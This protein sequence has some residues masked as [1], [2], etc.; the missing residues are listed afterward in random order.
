MSG[1][2]R[3]NAKIAP[4][5]RGHISKAGASFSGARRGPCRPAWLRGSLVPAPTAGGAAA[6][7]LDGPVP[8]PTGESAEPEEPARSPIDVASLLLG[9]LFVAVLVAVSAVRL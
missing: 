5:L 2:V 8:V 7:T 3:G 1:S 4:G 6:G 9:T